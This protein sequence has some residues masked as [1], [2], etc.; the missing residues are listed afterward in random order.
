MPRFYNLYSD[1]TENRQLICEIVEFS[2]NQVI[3]K[4]CLSSIRSLVIHS[5]LED[6]K[7]IS[8]NGTRNL[9][10]SGFYPLE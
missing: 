3:A 7:T 2:D 8:V 5:S 9:N 6:F 10:L 1:D 4:W